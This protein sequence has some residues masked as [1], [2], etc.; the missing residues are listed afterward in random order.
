MA[1]LPIMSVQNVIIKAEEKGVAIKNNRMRDRWGAGELREQYAS[2]NDGKTFTL[3]HW[4]TEILKLNLRT[5]K[6]LDYYG[7]GNSDRDAV[8][9]ALNYFGIK[10][11]VH[12]YPS[13][14]EFIIK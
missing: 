1:S 6:I 13:H 4:G 9:T 7:E 10:G 5:L 11:D 14:D 3:R 8:Q 12:Y 2:T